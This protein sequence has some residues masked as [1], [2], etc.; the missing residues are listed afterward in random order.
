[1]EPKQSDVL[2]GRGACFNQHP[3]NKY[4]RRMLDAHMDAYTTGTKKQKMVISHA[5]V[6]AIYSMKPAGR[7]LKR[8]NS[9]GEWEELSRREASN[10]VAQAMAY[11]VRSEMKL[12]HKIPAASSHSK[13]RN[14]A[15]KASAAISRHR[16]EDAKVDD[17][18]VREN[19]R[20]HNDLF[21][22]N[23][24]LQQQLL[25]MQGSQSGPTPF[26]SAPLTVNELLPLAR[27]QLIS[28]AQIQQLYFQQQQQQLSF[29]NLFGQDTLQP[30]TQL[31][32]IQSLSAPSNIDFLLQANLLRSI[33]GAGAQ[34]SSSLQHQSNE[35]A[36]HGA[37]ASNNHI[38][39]QSMFGGSIAPQQG[40]QLMDPVQRA[41]ILRP[42]FA[43]SSLAASI[44]QPQ[45]QSLGLFQHPLAPPSFG[46]N[47][48]MMVM[49]LLQRNSQHPRPNMSAKEVEVESKEDND[50]ND[51]H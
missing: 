7:F 1:M 44:R 3:G 51:L 28:Q 30:Q 19:P 41:A 35:H 16:G 32:S 48:Q 21:H 10:K 29:Q 34:P 50:N 43:E 5:I 42:L 23:P 24:S 6:D 38:P 39:N 12:S 45:S 17:D 46:E 11:A 8:F 25:L 26:P 40:G 36:R 13:E 14:S 33:Y 15:S 20:G 37:V 47:H 2:S 49:E 4:F 18:G 22:G 31:S 27:A 9:T